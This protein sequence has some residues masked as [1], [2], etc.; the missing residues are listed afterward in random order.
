MRAEL[1]SLSCY[2]IIHLYDSLLYVSSENYSD[3]VQEHPVKHTYCVQYHPTERR[4]LQPL[5]PVT[6]QHQDY[7]LIKTGDP[8]RSA[9][10]AALLQDIGGYRGED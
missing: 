5:D 3:Y 8:S 1:D 9:S 7:H 4:E 10:T 2:D 6:T